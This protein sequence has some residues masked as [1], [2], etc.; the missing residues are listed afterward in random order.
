MPAPLYLRVFISSP[1][2]VA[3]ERNLARRLLKDE[4][5]YDPLL[6]GKVTF[7]AVSWDDPAAST[8][9][10][11]TL[12]PQEAVN[13]FGCRPSECD[14]V[15]VVLWSRLGTQLKIDGTSY[16]SGT[17]YEEGTARNFFGRRP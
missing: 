2:D 7:D 8:P 1:G 9:M 4:L 12:T 10:V 15:I 14:I 17:E 5:P 3:D 11:A 13:R 16:L 6:R